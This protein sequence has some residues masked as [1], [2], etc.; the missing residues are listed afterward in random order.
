MAL[1]ALAAIVILLGP[2]HRVVRQ[3]SAV[4]PARTRGPRSGTATSP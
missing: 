1:Q 2:K 4:T 3:R